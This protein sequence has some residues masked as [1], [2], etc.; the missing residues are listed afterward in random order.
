MPILNASP[1]LAYVGRFA[2]SPSGPLHFGSLVTALGSY[3][4]A[5]KLQGKWLVRIEDI[6]PPREI[7]GAS[8][9]ILETLEQHHLYWDDTPVYQSQRT[10]LY[11]EKIND[12]ATQGSTFFCHCTRAQLAS[13]TAKKLC[14][15]ADNDVSADDAAVRFKNSAGIVS[16]Y[17]LVQQQVNSVVRD[18]QAQFAIKRKDGLFAYQLAVVVDDIAQGISEVVRGADLLH[19]TFYQLA[20]Y[21][22]FGAQPPR[23]AHLPLVLNANGAKLSKQNHAL[24][25]DSQQAALNLFN[26]MEFLGLMPPASLAKAAP[27]D[28]L[29]WAID[30]WDLSAVPRKIAC[31]DNRI[32]ALYSI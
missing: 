20:L 3:L 24:A 19:A 26:A 2:P 13:L 23:F 12:L 5:R 32:K 29:N 22:A 30:A 6:D 8:A 27:R 28:M 11:Q 17:D 14:L 15:C 25:I 7:S 21:K 10:A 18:T 9:R 16:F 4:Q 1:S 31:N